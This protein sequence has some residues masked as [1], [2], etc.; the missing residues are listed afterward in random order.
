LLR[1]AE[2]SGWQPAHSDLRLLV[3]GSDAID[4]ATVKRVQQ[5]LRAPLKQFYGLSEVSPLIA[6]TPQSMNEVPEGAVGRINP[7]W[8]LQCLDKHDQ[9]VG[10]GQP[11]QIAVR[12]GIIN[13][14][15][16]ADDTAKRVRNGWFLTGDMG[17]LDS[18]GYLYL[19][20]RV[21][22]RINRAGKKIS[23][24]SIEAVLREI[25]GVA[26]AVVFA[27][28]DSEYGQRVGAAV[29]C[30]NERLKARD[31]REAAA[32]KLSHDRLPEHVVITDRL[33][34]SA[35]GKI[36]RSKL[37]DYYQLPSGVNDPQGNQDAAA[38]G[39]R[40]AIEEQLA[41]IWCAV[42]GIEAVGTRDDFFELGGNSL[43]AMQICSRIHEA[44]KVDIPLRC[45]FETPT[46]AGLSAELE[47]E[48][49]EI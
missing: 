3:T 49:F 36:Q 6:V 39:P 14:V 24:G 2:I 31:I 37:A 43:L 32:L 48:S 34:L 18:A 42:L 4:P 28:P 7:V 22:D 26:D 16:N 15:V 44:F 29:V 19:T 17:Y 1:R 40:H 23:V 8:S 45:L 33:P 10:T 12:G 20:G 5:L 25:P 35:A 21:D 11:G 9:P 30:S 41:G 27:V 47:L 38:V 46:V 13:P